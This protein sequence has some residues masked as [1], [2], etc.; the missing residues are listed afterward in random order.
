MKSF[1]EELDVL[2]ERKVLEKHPGPVT[3]ISQFVIVPKP[4]KPGQVRIA[5]DSRVANKDIIRE[6]FATSITEKICYD[7]VGA[8]VYS[9]IDFNKA[10]HQIELEE[11]R[12]AIAN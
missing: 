8:T 5:V 6:R 9:E 11:V 1:E 4:K 2:L 3:W 10:F 7:L 12:S